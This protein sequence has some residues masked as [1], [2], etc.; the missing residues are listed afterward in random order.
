MSDTDLVFVSLLHGMFAIALY[1]RRQEA[2]HLITDRVG[3]KPLFY[4]GA[5]KGRVVFAS[6][7]TPLRRSVSGGLKIDFNALDQYLSYRIVPSP[8][9]SIEIFVGCRQHRS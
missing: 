1:D 8:R 4:F 7:L 2:L 3:K 9:T 6:E 5:S